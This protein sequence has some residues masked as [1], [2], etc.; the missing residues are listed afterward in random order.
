[1][2][3]VHA[4]ALSVLRLAAVGA[5]A[6]PA[7]TERALAHVAGCEIC[8][9]AFEIPR[10]AACERI[11]DELA[12]AALTVREGGDLPGR[13][14]M[15]SAHLE[16]CLRCRTVLTELATEPSEPGPMTRSMNPTERFERALVEGMGEPET[17]V[18]LRAAER[19]GAL[20]RPGAAALASLAAAAGGDPE[21]DVRAAALMA[22][23][24]LDTQVAI[25]ERVVEAWAE[26]PAAAAPYI[27]SVLERLS[28][29]VVGGVTRLV[30]RKGRRPGRLIV[31]GEEGIRGNIVEEKHTLWL[32]LRGLPERLERTRPVIALPG[33]LH[34]DAPNV[35]WP[36]QPPGIL[37]TETP[38]TGG[39]LEVLLARGAPQGSESLFRRM[40][41]LAPKPPASGS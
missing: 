28:G 30:T 22:L 5:E 6:D 26:T 9:A 27:A 17:I 1:M 24:R 36:E 32:R 41:L 20:A 15:V 23:D 33:A 8:G 21:E 10:T 3:D 14:P 12:E 37:H 19:L 39:T 38:V 25:P 29:G 13:H 18:R 34:E 7:E 16:A 2:P 11:E 40:Y 35:D 31:S 4:T